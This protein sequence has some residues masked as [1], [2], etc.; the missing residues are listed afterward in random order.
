MR[1]DGVLAKWNDERGFGFIKPRLGGAEVFV[2]ISEFPK[3][4]QRPCVGE[5]VSFEVTV[6]RAGKKKA[7][8][9]QCLDRRHRAS[10]SYQDWQAVSLRARTGT[11]L[12]WLRN[13]GLVA[14]FALLCA[15]A[16]TQFS[17]YRQWGSLAWRDITKQFSAILAPASSPAPQAKPSVNTSRFRCDGRTYCSQMTSCEEATFFI[18]NC[19]G[20]KMDG[21][22]DGIPCEQQWCTSGRSLFN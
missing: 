4:G 9:V 8:Q 19:P 3:D 10:D 12:R 22:G 5:R 18:N 13:L 7:R 1:C 6:D 21:N 2:H 11:L 15:V 14:V 20:T 17:D 16:Y